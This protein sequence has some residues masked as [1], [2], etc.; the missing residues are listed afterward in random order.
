MARRHIGAQRRWGRADVAGAGISDEERGAAGGDDEERGSGGLRGK[1]DPYPRV[2]HGR[3]DHGWRSHIEGGAGGG[4]VARNTDRGRR[5]PAGDVPVALGALV[6]KRSRRT[7]PEPAEQHPDRV[8]ALGGRESHKQNGRVS[9][10]FQ[11]GTHNGNTRPDVRNV[12][13]RTSILQHRAY[14]D[15]NAAAARGAAKRRRARSAAEAGGG[16]RRASRWSSARRIRC[17]QR[18][19]A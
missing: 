17:W 15:A 19:R 16:D 5:G 12:T 11:S 13:S 7:E 2:V 9:E 6:R 10:A 3:V 4:P 18:M 8:Y 1:R 14:R